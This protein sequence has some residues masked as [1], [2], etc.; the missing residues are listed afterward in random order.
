VFFLPDQLE[1]I[2]YGGRDGVKSG[3]LLKYSHLKMRVI[4][5]IYSKWLSVNA[6]NKINRALC[7]YISFLYK[8]SLS[9]IPF[10]SVLKKAVFM[11]GENMQQ[12]HLR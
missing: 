9:Q 7:L 6:T 2:N 10:F 1:R 5:L 3:R 11:M 8:S 12:F 4:E